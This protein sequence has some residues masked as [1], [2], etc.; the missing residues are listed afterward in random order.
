MPGVPWQ[1]VGGLVRCVAGM[2]LLAAFILGNVYRSNLKAMLTIPRINIPFDS[3]DGLADSDVPTAILRGSK[4]HQQILV[5]IDR[6]RGGDTSWQTVCCAWP[7][8]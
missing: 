2:W 6:T 5:G 8:W 4:M 3:V 1:P 7:S